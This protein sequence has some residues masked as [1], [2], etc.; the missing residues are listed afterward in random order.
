MARTVFIATADIPLEGGIAFICKSVPVKT[1]YQVLETEVDLSPTF[2]GRV[3]TP[4]CSKTSMAEP[5]ANPHTGRLNPGGHVKLKIQD[6]DILT[7]Y[8]DTGAQVSV[9]P[10]ALSTSD[11]ELAGAG[12]VPLV[13]LD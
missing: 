2:V 4:S 6:Q 5:A 8:I 11:R 12:D 7:R 3:T 10:E 13:T 9:M 1:V